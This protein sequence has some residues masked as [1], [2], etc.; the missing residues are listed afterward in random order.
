L[1]RSCSDEMGRVFAC[2]ALGCPGAGSTPV[3]GEGVQ[4]FAGSTMRHCSAL[5]IGAMEVATKLATT[6]QKNEAETG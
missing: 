4:V 3:A 2:P 1:I 6:S 5:G